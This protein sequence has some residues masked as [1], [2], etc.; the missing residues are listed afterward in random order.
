MTPLSP[1]FLLALLI[2]A[3]RTRGA[4]DT[5]QLLLRRTKW[6]RLISVTDSKSKTRSVSFP[7]GRP[8]LSAYT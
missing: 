2:Q 6:G 5:V 4:V 8:R 3:H 1:S 7:T